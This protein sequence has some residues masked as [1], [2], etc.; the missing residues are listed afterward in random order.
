MNAPKARPGHVVDDNLVV[1]HDAHVVVV[2]KPE[3]ISSIVHEGETESVEQRVQDWL[4]AREP[5]RA[6][7]VHVVHR[8]D[9][10]TSGVMLFARTM[11]AKLALKEQFRA[12]TVGR[13]YLALV[14]GAMRDGTLKF[15]M[16]RNRGDGLRGVT[17]DAN[18]G[19]FS[20]TH[21][22]VRE[23]F[24]RCSLVECR[25]ETGRTHQIRIH[26]SHV[27]HPIVGEN[28]YSKGFDGPLLTAD[29]V[30]LH[31]AT[32]SFDHPVERRRL[33]FDEPLAPSFR[34]YLDRVAVR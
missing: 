24:A 10:V 7:A 21:V 19:Y 5:K 27:G 9:K 4:S 26:L 32:L 28:L 15:R 1:Y 29:R 12:H 34:E 22:R 16:V 11:A 3:G 14:N 25:L 23:Q 33:A 18:R 31:A 30:M 17:N 6:A 13:L 8:L 20:T 2:R